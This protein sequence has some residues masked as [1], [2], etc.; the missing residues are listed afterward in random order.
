MYPHLTTVCVQRALGAVL[1]NSVLD[2]VRRTKV[3]VYDATTNGVE[4]FFLAR[5]ESMGSRADEVL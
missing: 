4:N 3:T 1:G 2:A 5:H